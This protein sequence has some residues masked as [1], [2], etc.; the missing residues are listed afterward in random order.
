ML[1][2]AGLQDARPR[3]RA[4][5]HH[6]LGREDVQVARHRH[7]PAALS[8]ARHEPGV[9]ALLHRRQAERERRGHGLQ[10]GRLHRAGQQRSGRQVREHREPRRGLHHQA[11]SAASCDASRAA[12]LRA[13]AQ[14]HG[15]GIAASLRGARI[16]QGDARGHGARRP[17]Q[18]VRRRAEAVGARQG[19][20]PARGAAATCC[21]TA[22][23]AF[24]HAHALPEAGA[25][26]ARR[27][28]AES[29]LGWA[30][31]DVERRRKLLPAGTASAR[32]SIS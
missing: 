17:R 13:D 6:R 12:P 31:P 20:G 3:L 15:D 32:T 11:S 24:S 29:F 25:A 5:L 9:A 28:S 21:S 22:L 1:E 8:R 14:A 18:P 19:A 23:D 30:A 27:A 10:P 7:Q 4:R 26:A 16:R 2:F